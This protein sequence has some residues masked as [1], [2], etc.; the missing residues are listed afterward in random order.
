MT[1]E[2]T[3][4]LRIVFMGTPEFAVASLD[5]LVRAGHEIAA[6]VTA[7][8]KPAGRGLQ[9][10]QSA[11]KHYALAHHIPVMQPPKLR[12]PGFIADL[13]AL[14]ADLFV[15]VAFRMLPEVIWSMPP[16]GTI[17]LHASLLPRYRGAA[18]IHRA[19][20]AGEKRTG[21][22][23]FFLQQEIDTGQVIARRE[24]DIGPEETTGELHDRLMHIGA[25]CLA[26][27]VQMIAEGRVIPV[28]QEQL[29]ESGEELRHA[30]KLF[31]EDA[32]IRW[33]RTVEEVHNHVR[34]LSPFPAAWTGLEGKVFKIY[35]GHGQKALHDV[36][37]GKWETD[38]KT[39][40]RFGC[41]DGW[42]YAVRVQAEGKKA[43]D[44]GEFLRGFSGA[45]QAS[46]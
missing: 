7:P 8:D 38:G 46:S 24:T 6:V 4:P 36:T 33:D 15:V 26:A 22:T 5:A 45:R 28:P 41:A 1:P 11:V 31:R 42:Y 30:P 23:T 35:S 3:S 34:G 18:P 40:L 43:M 25:E 2:K 17:N 12:D 21:V 27:T 29:I 39:Y 37:P 44:V 13:R 19:V 20:M 9:L 14:S 32:L 10:Q 16:K